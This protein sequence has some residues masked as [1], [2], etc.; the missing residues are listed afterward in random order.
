MK[1]KEKVKLIEI[2]REDLENKGYTYE[3]LFQR[4][5]KFCSL[6]GITPEQYKDEKGEISFFKE[7][8]YVIVQLLIELGNPYLQRL[9]ANR[10]VGKDVDEIIQLSLE[11][12]SNMMSEILKMEDDDLIQLWTNIIDSLGETDINELNQNIMTK[13]KEIGDIVNNLNYAEKIQLLREMNTGLDQFHSSI[14]T[15]FAGN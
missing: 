2:A 14:S 15:R 11:F 3:T 5:K 1:T 13:V 8:R 7:E 6:L 12:R 10:K 4:F 9:V